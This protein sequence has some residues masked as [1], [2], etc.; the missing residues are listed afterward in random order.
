MVY[1]LFIPIRPHCSEDHSSCSPLLIKWCTP[2]VHTG[3]ISQHQSRKQVTSP[4]S[5]LLPH[6]MKWWALLL[7]WNTGFLLSLVGHQFQQICSE[8]TLNPPICLCFPSPLR[9]KKGPL[10]LTGDENQKRHLGSVWNLWLFWVI[11]ASSEMLTWP[12]LC[13]AIAFKP[14]FSSLILK[15]KVTL[16]GQEHPPSDI[17]TV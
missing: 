7:F 1:L 4:T 5:L 9:F 17:H 11:L 14:P 13:H 16:R 6:T 2:G 10:Q 12:S 15:T 3:T 8:V